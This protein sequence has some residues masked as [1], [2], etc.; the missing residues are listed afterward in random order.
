MKPISWPWSKSHSAEYSTDESE[1][2][3]GF[4]KRKINCSLEVLTMKVKKNYNVDESYR[5]QWDISGL[6][7]DE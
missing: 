2:W 5:N 1:K 4:S 6:S 3:F 7:S